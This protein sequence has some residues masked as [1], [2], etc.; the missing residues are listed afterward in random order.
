MKNIKV[1]FSVGDGIIPQIVSFLPRAEQ[2]IKKALLFAVLL[3]LSTFSFSQ[4]IG[5]EVLSPQAVDST[6]VEIQATDNAKAISHFSG[7][8]SVTNNGISLVPTFSLGKPAAIFNLAIGNRKLTFEPD[9]RFA[10]EGKPW[11]FLFWWRYK[12][13]TTD[14]FSLRVGAH[15][16]YNFR[17]QTVSMNGVPTEAIVTR[18]FL[19]GEVAPNYLLSKNISVGTYYLYSRAFDTGVP[20]NTHFLTLNSNISNIKLTN[21]FYMQVTPQLYYL[22]QDAQDGFYATS[23]FTVFKKNLPLSLSAIVNKTIQ[24]EITASKDFVWSVN[25]IYTF[26][27]NYSRL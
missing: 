24:T 10:L 15:P 16:A 8:I 26:H 2:A 27:K 5:S 20:S 1:D 11:S 21:Q 9:L 13:V 6:K 12:L 25:L 19:A 17:T 14:K 18:R 3:H 22:K 4:T 7:A 23:V